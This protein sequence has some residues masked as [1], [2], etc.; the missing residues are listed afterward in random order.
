LP[1]CSRAS[2]SRG[3]LAMRIIV[4]TGILIGFLWL[5]RSGLYAAFDAYGLWPYMAI[6]VGGTVLII[7]AAFGW[8][9]YETRSRRS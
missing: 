8:D 4:C 5:V 2:D 7:A 1:L 6:C 9:Y 3:A